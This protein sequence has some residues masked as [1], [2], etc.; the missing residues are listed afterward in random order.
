[1]AEKHNRQLA[2]HFLS[3]ATPTASSSSVT[4]LP[5]KKLAAWLVL[6]SKFANPKALHSSSALRYLYINLLSHP[7]RSLQSTALTCLSTYKSPALAQYEHRI[8]T[9]LDDTRWRDEL[10]LLDLGLDSPDSRTE[11]GLEIS[12]RKEA[13]EVIVRL[14]FGVMLER[15]GKSKGS[16][17]GDRRKAVLNALAGCGED[18][19]G[20]LV[21]LMLRTLRP[22][23][24]PFGWDRNGASSVLGSADSG[25]TSKSDLSGGAGIKQITGFLTFLGD[26]L[27][28]LGSRLVIYWPVLIEMTIG[29]TSA[30]QTCI[31]GLEVEENNVKEVEGIVDDL[32]V[33]EETVASPSSSPL[34]SSSPKIIRSIRQLGL[35]RFADFFR[36]LVTFDF[37]S[38]M[39]SAFASFITPR[40]PVLDRENTQSPSALLELFHV[41]TTDSSYI[42][43]L[44]FYDPQTLPKLYDCLVATNVKPS[45]VSRVFDVVDNLL[46]YSAENELIR[47][48][49]VNHTSLT[50]SVISLYLLNGRRAHRLSQR[51]LLNVK[52]VSSLKQHSI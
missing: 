2:P 50:C 30:A 18:E 22:T 46:G 16:G 9:L 40:L 6:F 25:N 5:K 14:L 8:R 52:L 45:V 43:F 1:M 21:D 49:F 36:V 10:A 41:W 32:D 3:L 11:G 51:P 19:L 13:L 39:R 44:V 48:V 20:L 37:S 47:E 7:D 38:Y 12:S 26:L 31:T 33:P 28:I 42:P 34:S 35:K 15:K 23:L 24:R 27:K 29:L 4:K 17:A